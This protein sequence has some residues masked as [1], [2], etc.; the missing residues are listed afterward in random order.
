[1]D[2]VRKRAKKLRGG[3]LQARDGAACS[4]ESVRLAYK[5][6]DPC[7]EPAASAVAPQVCKP[8]WTMRFQSASAV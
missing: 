8:N 3:A 2:T 6:V 1:M 5:S 7:A 4:R